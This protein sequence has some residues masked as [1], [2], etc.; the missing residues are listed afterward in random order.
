M[1]R[2]M[3]RARG[4]TLLELIMTI[5]IVAILA[6][7]AVPG[8]VE[9]RYDAERT[10][11]VN[12]LIHA[13]YLA[14][15]E[16]IKR[17]AIVSL[18]RSPDGVTCANSSSGWNE[19]W[20]VFVNL[21]RDDPPQR[22]PNEPIITRYQGW[23]GGTITSNRP[24]YSFRPAHQGLVNGTVLFCDPRGGATARAIIISHVGR[25]R[26]SKRDSDNKPLRCAAR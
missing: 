20:M 3:R 9:F 14:R 21:D 7:V 26:V 1:E 10:A 13:L 15:S 16:S 12:G 2:R 8:F 23:R 18:C 19:G 17:V 24:A 6:T 25:P 4:V 5:A 11:A 22:D